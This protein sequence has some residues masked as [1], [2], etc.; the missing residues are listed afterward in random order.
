MHFFTLTQKILKCEFLLLLLVLLLQ[1]VLDLF[2]RLVLKQ[3]PRP[4]IM[5]LVENYSSNSKD[6]FQTTL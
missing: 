6:N 4:A 2:S 3:V 1:S 5:A